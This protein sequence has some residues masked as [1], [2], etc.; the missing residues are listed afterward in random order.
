M[1]KAIIYAR[2]SKG[3][4]DVSAS[5]EEQI[6]RC[7]AYAEANN[8]EVIAEPFKDLNTP[9]ETYPSGAIYETK[10]EHD[11]DFQRWFDNAS[12]NKKFR[13]GLGEALKHIKEADCII[14]DDIT[15]LYRPYKSSNLG[16]MILS[17]LAV[18]K[19]KLVFAK[20]GKIDT[21][22]RKDIALA[23]FINEIFD[24]DREIKAINSRNQLKKRKSEG[25]PTTGCKAFG[26]IYN[27]DDESIRFDERKAEAIKYI[28][29]KVSEYVPYNQILFEL[30]RDFSDCVNKRWYSSNIYNITRNYV[31]TGNFNI[32]TE[33]EQKNG[34]VILKE[35]DKIKPI[36]PLFLFDKVQKVMQDKRENGG[37]AKH[38]YKGKERKNFLPLSGFMRCSN[39]GSKLVVL[40]DNQKIYYQC[41]GAI[42]AKD[43]ECRKSRVL[44]D[45]SSFRLQGVQQF[46]LPFL[47]IALVEQQKQLIIDKNITDEIASEKNKK[48]QLENAMQVAF[49]MLTDNKIT[50]E[51]FEKMTAKTQNKINELDMAIKVLESR[52]NTDYLIEN[53]MLDYKISRV[54]HGDI[55]NNLYTELLHKS[56]N[57]ITIYEDKIEFDSKAGMFKID[58]II[59]KRIKALPPAAI[60]I[61]RDIHDEAL[62]N[63]ASY[64][65]SVHYPSFFD[66]DDRTE[67]TI[68]EFDKL[69]IVKIGR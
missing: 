46:L 33:E 7:Y 67:K 16:R 30:N 38:N 54:L 52:N 48:L 68:A 6:R 39:C 14:L 15:R 28:F 27:K 32:A 13:P 29:N 31:Y 2:Q 5:V 42:M 61:D 11:D 8:L 9:G 66:E 59:Y 36:I 22:S 19:C 47:V 10:A 65:I 24:E 49:Q 55:D 58:R 60:K 17:R 26:A 51:M 37:K 18:A 20:G 53:K 64:T 69:K 40:I 12:T 1:E 62:Y 43:E 44:A 35:Y 3:N 50:S 45:Y 63:N 21:E 25:K 23:N 56:I 34:I 4:N 57:K 41:Q